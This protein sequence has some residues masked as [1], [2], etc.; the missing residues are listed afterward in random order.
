MSLKLEPP[1]VAQAP[2]RF[3]MTQLSADKLATGYNGSVS[4]FLLN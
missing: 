3:E 1:R 2:F 4:V